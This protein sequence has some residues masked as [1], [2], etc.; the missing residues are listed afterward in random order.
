MRTDPV[1]VGSRVDGPEWLQVE[2]LTVRYG[3]LVA[4][5][6][7]SM[8][9]RQGEL[10]G[11][12][13]P[14]GSGK[15]ST[16]AA[17]SRLVK[18]SSGRLIWKGAEYTRRN[19]SDMIRLG[20]ARTFQTVRLVP[21]LS[22]LENVVAGADAKQKGLGLAE[23]VF[24]PRRFH[25]YETAVRGSAREALEQVG[26]GHLRENDVR[27]LSYGQQRRVELARAL[28]ADPDLILLDEPTAGMSEMER[29][30]IAVLLT[31]IASSGKSILVVEHN[32][33]FINNICDWVYV[34][35]LGACIAEGPAR[36]VSREPE[37][38]AAYVGG[39]AS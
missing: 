4:V 35:N 6:E 38:V 11:L 3:G 15:S 10:C 31:S 12:I 33:R 25:R 21:T 7:F 1:G 23:A 14:N 17:L 8:V 20:V 5:A 22:V 37:V 29:D 18:P 28:V 32:L 19:P 24:L 30:E 16:L 9:I 2:R 26:L 34:M 36:V 27:S 13:G 39:E